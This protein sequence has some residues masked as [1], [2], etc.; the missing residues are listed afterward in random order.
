M[1]PTGLDRRIQ[2]NLERGNDRR[3]NKLLRKQNKY[4]KEM[5]ED[6]KE[7]NALSQ[8]NAEMKNRIAF[9]RSTAIGVNEI[10]KD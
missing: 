1:Q 6:A 2:K 8:Q 4:L 5:A 10:S 3:V 9:D 7:N